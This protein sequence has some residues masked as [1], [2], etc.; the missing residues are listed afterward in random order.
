MP[1]DGPILA[2][3]Q[4]NGYGAA[5]FGLPCF[6]VANRARK[7]AVTP[8]A[9]SSADSQRNSRRP[10]AKVSSPQDPQFAPGLLT[11][12]NNCA[13]NTTASDMICWRALIPLLQRLNEK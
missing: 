1:A 5:P 11:L 2:R 8:Q 3:F 9:I 13:L 4:V 6:I 7:K 10:L 12:R